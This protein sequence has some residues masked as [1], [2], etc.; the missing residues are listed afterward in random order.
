MRVANPGPSSSSNFLFDRSMLCI[1]PQFTVADGVWPVDLEDSSQA[2]VDKGLHFVDG[3]VGY[4]P[5]LCSIQQDYLHVGV[6]QPDLC[7]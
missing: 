2:V 1:F 4:P 3:G 6:E 5:C 7:A